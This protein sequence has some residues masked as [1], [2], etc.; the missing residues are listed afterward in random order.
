VDVVEEPAF[1]GKAEVVFRG[2][3]R[4]NY[5]VNPETLAPKSPTL[6]AERESAPFLPELPEMFFCASPERRAISTR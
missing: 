5:P 1:E 2:E 6:P 3:I 4:F